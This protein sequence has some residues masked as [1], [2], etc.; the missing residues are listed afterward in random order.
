MNKHVTFAAAAAFAAAAFAPGLAS[1]LP[2]AG[3]DVVAPAGAQGVEQVRMVC[4]AWGRCWR[5]GPYWGGGY[6]WRG[7][8]WHG[9]GWHGGGW[10]GGGWHGGG[11]H[12]GHHGGWH[13][14]RHGGWRR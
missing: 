1:A 9:G 8:G 3:K 12:G 2:A 5:T 13:G 11:W 10:H 4:D 14:G 6:G 7:G